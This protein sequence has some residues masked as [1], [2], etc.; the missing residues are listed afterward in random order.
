[1]RTVEEAADRQ[2]AYILCATKCIPE[3]L[4]TPTILQPLL[5]YLSDHPVATPSPTTVVLLQNGVGIEDDLIAYLT[6]E[7]LSSQVVVTSACAWVDTTAIDGGKKVTQFGTE[8]LVLGVHHF[9][10]GMKI[11]GKKALKGFCD[12]LKLAGT[13]AVQVDDID[14]ARWRKVLWYVSLHIYSLLGTDR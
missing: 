2:Y 11:E 12:I 3:V 9:N 5:S 10:D 13:E 4:S 1:M 6:S 8:K 14:A 7:N